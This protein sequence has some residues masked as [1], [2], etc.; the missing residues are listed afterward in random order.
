MMEW[1]ARSHVAILVAIL[2]FAMVIIV[3][4]IV[5]FHVRKLEKECENGKSARKQNLEGKE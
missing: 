1:M 4:T 2:L 5:K 3:H